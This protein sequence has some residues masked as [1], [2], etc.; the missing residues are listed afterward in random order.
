MALQQD[1][2][3]SITAQETVVARVLNSTLTSAERQ[4]VF[5][6]LAA[7]ELEFVFLAPEQ[8]SRDDTIAALQRAQPSLF[9]VDEAHCISQ[10]GH[11]FR[12][13]YLHLER[14][15]AALNHP[16]VLA[17]TATASPPVRQEMIQ[18]LC[19]HDPVQVVQGF[20]RPNLDLSVM[21]FY[22]DDAKLPAL[23]AAVAQADLPGIVYAATRQTTGDIAQQLQDA[24]VRAAAYH[25]GLSTAERDQ[26]QTQFM[27]DDLDVVVAT[28]AFG[29]G[30]DK[31]NVRFVFH[32]DIPG[33]I[34]AYYQEIGRAGRDG[35]PSSVK[36]FYH[37]DHLKLQRFLGSSGTIDR[38]TLSQLAQQL[39]TQCEPVAMDAI[40]AHTPLS[41]RKLSTALLCLEA[42]ALVKRLANGRVVAQP[43]D[44]LPK[45]L[46]QAETAQQRRHA[47]EQSCL[48]MMQDYAESSVCRREAL[49]SYF[50]GP[51][52]GPC[53]SCDTCR[54]HGADLASSGDA[55]S[56]SESV[57]EPGP[58]PLGSTIIH[59]QFA[60]GQVIRYEDDKVVILFETVGY[61][62]FVT[63][64][65]ADSVRCLAH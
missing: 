46:D 51:F 23:L 25:A 6:A 2:V 60:R 37:P 8:L 15:I 40:E 39:Q 5:D 28:T 54:Q 48:H 14:E 36:L 35:K 34:D 32:Y 19:L 29:M 43:V 52:Q 24:G 50:G 4:A 64:L 12:T 61:K 47:A 9:V 30:I 11:D 57:D 3:Q 59:T 42:A 49:L 44:D 55:P 27:G 58:L 65:I 10:W 7:G 21:R 18:Q 62:T 38:E 20:D 16:T 41:T 33:S 63:A 53:D 17:L 22:D 56:R 26:M 13:D 45:Q 31:S 1:Q